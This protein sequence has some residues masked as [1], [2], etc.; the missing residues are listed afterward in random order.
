MAWLDLFRRLVKPKTPARAAVSFDDLS[1]RC[2]RPDGLVETVRWAEL[3]AVVIHTT[4]AGPFVEDVFWVLAGD[5]SDCVIPSDAVGMKPLL[6][7]MQ[8]LPGFDN[9]AVIE[10]MGSTDNREFLCWQR[11]AVG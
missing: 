3:R 6:N 7:R 11:Q 10:A 1:V 2:R 8:E 5:Q 9:A 4:D